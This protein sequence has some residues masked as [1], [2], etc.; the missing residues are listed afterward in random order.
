MEK[1]DIPWAEAAAPQA[2]DEIGPAVGSFAQKHLLFAFLLP[3][4]T[5]PQA[6]APIGLGNRDVKRQPTRVFKRRSTFRLHPATRELEDW[7]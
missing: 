7:A 6:A 4:V 1:D 5:R 2:I 3:G